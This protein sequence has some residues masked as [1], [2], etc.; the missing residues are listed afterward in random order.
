MKPSAIVMA[1]T[2]TSAVRLVEGARDGASPGRTAGPAALEDGSSTS[3]PTAP[4]RTSTCVAVA[5]SAARATASSPSGPV[6]SPGSA[7]RGILRLSAATPSPTTAAAANGR[8]H[9]TLQASRAPNVGASA[10][11]RLPTCLLYT[12]DA[13]D[14]L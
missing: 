11:P 9:D 13:A 7:S 8:R 5:S 6:A 2:R 4:S 10:R 12:S 1:Y 3:Q 14:D